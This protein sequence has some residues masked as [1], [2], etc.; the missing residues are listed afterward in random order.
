MN[1]DSAARAEELMILSDAVESLS[2]EVAPLGLRTLL[3]EPGTF[4]TDFLSQ[5]NT[6]SV[7]NRI[8]DYQELSE[9][10]E[11]AFAELNG[12]QLGDP[13]KGVNVIIDVIKGANEAKG[14]KWPNSLP[15]GSDAVDAIRK[16]CESTLR[17][18]DEWESLSKSTNL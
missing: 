13:K 6:K 17:E 15:L 18:I 3:I 12:K 2:A 7:E 5:R 9:T 8:E 4:M 10:M 11:S 14:K 16:K 1:K